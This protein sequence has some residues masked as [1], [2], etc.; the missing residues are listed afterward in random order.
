MRRSGRVSVQ[1]AG[2]RFPTLSLPAEAIRSV[3]ILQALTRNRAETRPDAADAR[4]RGRTYAIR[5]D[6]VWR[7]ALAEAQRRWT[8]TDSDAS[9]GTI[10]AEART[11]LWKFVDDVQVDV[12]L[13]EAGLTR[14]DLRSQSRRGGGDLGAN[15]RRIR[16]FLRRL[17]AALARA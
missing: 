7:A 9:R 6:A 3:T 13:D 2:N 15:A 17:D 1:S 5:F 12:S 8:V 14:V 10:R 16:R 4:M 11:S